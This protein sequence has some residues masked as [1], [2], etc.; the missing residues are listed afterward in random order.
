M[1]IAEI[2]LTHP[3]LALTPTI[4][5]LPEMTIELE[6]QIIADEDTY[7][8]FFEVSGGD[9][10]AFDA[11]VAGDETVEDSAVIVEADEFRVYRMRLLPVERLV[12][13][14]AA[15]LGMRVLH[16]EAGDGGWVAKL[17][18]PETERLNRFRSY[19]ADR[20]VEFSVKRLYHAEDGRDGAYGL[21]PTQRDTL[22]AAYRA[23]YFEEP[24]DASL[25]DVADALGVSQSA[26]SGRL[27]R[28]VSALVAATLAPE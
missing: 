6:N 21:S 18:V 25:Q 4:R 11:A 27:R 7:Y 1:P 26:A 12:L 23:G 22:L 16:A 8:L 3:D 28:A 14:K 9:F 2:A 10:D 13:P 15:E 17:D 19:C 24:R 5:A 20:D